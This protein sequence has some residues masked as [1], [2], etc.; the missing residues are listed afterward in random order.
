[1]IINHPISRLLGRHPNL[2]AL[3]YLAAL[4]VLGITTAFV[5]ADGIENYNARNAALETLERLGKPARTSWEVP[6]GP[7]DSRPPGSS[8]LEGQTMTLASA[9]LLQRV[10]GAVSQ[11]EGSIISTEVEPYTRQPK[12]GT[13]KA[14]ANF[15]IQQSG[16]QKLLYDLEAGMPFLFVDQLVVVVA[17]NEDRR[18]RVL[19]T[20]S[21]LWRGEN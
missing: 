9:A 18:V 12:D 19:L 15:E 20:V 17:P 10:T 8:F 4:L 1:M 2:P 3:T 21:G 16:L 6:V 7:A 5:V 14:T 13:L 11:A